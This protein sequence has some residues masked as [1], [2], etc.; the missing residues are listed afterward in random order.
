MAKLIIG[1]AAPETFLM[2]VDIPTA[3]GIAQ[4]DFVAVN[5][6]ASE[7]A[8]VRESH[9]ESVAAGANELFDA[10]RR[11]AEIE[12]AKTAADDVDDDA[13]EKA[14]AALVKAVPESK[15][16]GLRAQ[17]SGEL[18]HKIT[19]SWDLDDEHSVEKLA[20]MCD[21]YPGAAEAV[22]RAYNDAREGLKTKNSRK[23]GGRSM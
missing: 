17:Y 11:E 15:I 19:T 14:I 3:T 20:E 1:K 6:A 10:A 8:K 4:V 22:F 2:H 7:W 12:Y 21:Q 13:K 9:A 16:L 23:S 5:M 18:I